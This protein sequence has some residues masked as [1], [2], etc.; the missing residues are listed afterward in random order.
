MT[1]LSICVSDCFRT[2]GLELVKLLYLNIVLSI[3][4]VLKYFFFTFTP[5]LFD[6]GGK[7]AFQ[8]NGIC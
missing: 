2:S 1:S 8:T 7:K 6:N 4:L 3:L 5:T